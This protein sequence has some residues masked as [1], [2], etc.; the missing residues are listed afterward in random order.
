MAGLLICITHIGEE[1]LKK[2]SFFWDR[3]VG[4]VV[5]NNGGN[6]KIRV[7]FS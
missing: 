2:V 5:G 3:G 6:R 7:L 1:M 4:E